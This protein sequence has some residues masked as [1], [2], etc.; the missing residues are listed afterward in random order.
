MFPGQSGPPPVGPTG[1]GFSPGG[2]GGGPVGPPGSY[3]GSMGPQ[4]PVMSGPPMGSPSVG[5]GGSG[6]GRRWLWVVAGV[7]VLVVVA[8]TVVAVLAG[9]G[10]ESGSGKPEQQSL[11]GPEGT[12]TVPASKNPMRPNQLWNPET[13]PDSVF[14]PFNFDRRG[15]EIC[16]LRF[17]V[18]SCQWRTPSNRG[19]GFSAFVYASTDSFAQVL[20]DANLVDHS[21]ITVGDRRATM[22]TL[23]ADSFK[24]RCDI[25]WGTSFGSIWVTIMTSMPD[26][27]PYD[28]CALVKELADRVYKH[29][30]N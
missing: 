12:I 16:D 20:S 14:E 4:G 19:F 5:S 1:P 11:V 8:V 13:L 15:T 22:Y 18:K 9:G 3:P 2:F 21:P 27:K 30:P 28:N 7:V 6:G 25:A 23:K 17:N 10:G 29:A 24:R 26:E